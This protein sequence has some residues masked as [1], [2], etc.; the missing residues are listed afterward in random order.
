M[1]MALV[2]ATRAHLDFHDKDGRSTRI[3]TVIFFVTAVGS[4]ASFLTWPV[5]WFSTGLLVATAKP[6]FERVGLVVNQSGVSE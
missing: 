2:V 4:V 3:L 1:A 6:S 5:F